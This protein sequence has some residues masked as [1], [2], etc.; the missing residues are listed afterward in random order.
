MEREET[1]VKL[2][3]ILFLLAVLFY[4]IAE[5][6]PLNDA[7]ALIPIYGIPSYGNVVPLG[8]FAYFTDFAKPFFM[9]SAVLALGFFC[10]A[11]AYWNLNPLRRAALNFVSTW[12][13][14]LAIP[15]IIWPLGTPYYEVLKYYLGLLSLMLLFTL[16]FMTLSWT[17]IEQK[18]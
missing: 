10:L 2:P 14:I 17:I 8:S 11:F 13:V 1:S 16:G 6:T 3:T 5:L 18:R 12:S 15:D 9:M 7:V 4:A